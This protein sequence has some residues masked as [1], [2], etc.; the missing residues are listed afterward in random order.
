MAVTC[1]RFAMDLIVVDFHTRMHQLERIVK[2]QFPANSY[3]F[4]FNILRKNA[5]RK[6][7]IGHLLIMFYA[8]KCSFRREPVNL[9]R[10]PTL[11]IHR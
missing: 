8:N 10:A 4:G 5:C 7:I 11:Y 1:M 2:N 9:S 6:L 3:I